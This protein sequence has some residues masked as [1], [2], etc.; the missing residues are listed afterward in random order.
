MPS[1]TSDHALGGA[2]SSAAVVKSASTTEAG[3]EQPLPTEKGG[4]ASSQ[5]QENSSSS[6]SIPDP[7][8]IDIIKILKPQIGKLQGVETSDHPLQTKD[9]KSSGHVLPMQQQNSSFHIGK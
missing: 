5:L 3:V 4:I 6:N 8:S 9:N 2:Q 1:Q 7:T